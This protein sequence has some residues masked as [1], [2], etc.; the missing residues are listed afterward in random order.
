MDKARDALLRLSGS[1]RLGKRLSEVIYPNDLPEF[2]RRIADVTLC[3]KAVFEVK[4]QGVLVFVG[5]DGYDVFYPVFGCAGFCLPQQHPADM[6]VQVLM[7]DIDGKI[8]GYPVGAARV[9]GIQISIADNN[10]FIVFDHDKGVPF[11]NAQTALCEI[12]LRGRFLLERESGVF[13]IIAV[14]FKAVRDIRFF[15][16]SYFHVPLPKIA[17][18]GGVET[19]FAL[20]KK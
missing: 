19:V 12:R 18:P 11:G 7:A 14:Y 15:K 8:G 9:E 3:D 5:D 1:N 10:S 20:N 13:D 17:L 6:L 2:N 4:I 16:I